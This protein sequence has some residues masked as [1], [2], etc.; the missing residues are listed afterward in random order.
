MSLGGD[1]EIYKSGSQQIV[2]NLDIFL[3]HTQ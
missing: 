3:E 2:R 1:Q